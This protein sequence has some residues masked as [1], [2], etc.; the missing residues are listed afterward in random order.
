MTLALAA[1]KDPLGT[2]LG[3]SG[4]MFAANVAAVIVGAVMGARLPRRRVLLLVAMAFV[5]FGALLIAEGFG[6]I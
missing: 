1:T 4:G 3:A 2:W 5:V 6:L